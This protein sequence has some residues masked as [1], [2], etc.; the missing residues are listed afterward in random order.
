MI[1]V[2]IMAGGTGGHVMPGLAVAEALRA[3]GATLSWL[4]TAAG[5]EAELVAR[6]GIDIDFIRIKGLRKSGAAR[7]AAMPF[8]LAWAL[9]QAAAVMRRRRP[10]AALGMGGF[11]AAP[12]GLVAALLRRPLV[13][14]EQNRVAGLTNRLLAKVAQRRLSGFPDARGLPGAEWV[15]NP[16]RRAIVDLP[17]PQTRLAGR[18]GALRV[19]VVGGSR[20]AEAFNRHLPNLLARLQPRPQIRHQCGANNADAVAA[21]YRDAGI[22]AQVHAFIDDMASAY[23]WCDLAICRAGALTVAEVCAAGA[24]AL[25]VPYPHA[26]SDHQT[27][28]AA[29]LESQGAARLV[30]QD[31]LVRGDWLGALAEWQRE[32]A[33]L[34]AMAA[35]ARR[36]ARPDAADEVAR[37]CLE[38]ANG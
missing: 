6:A 28:N 33:P 31:D 5:V 15:G 36:L 37:I 30:A 11:A 16:V 1:R 14:H 35:A 3:R 38:A 18:R 13:I 21:R 25:L 22:R 4:G 26:V 34:A 12:G 32:R 7:A 2:L 24:A 8:M 9:A 19:L 29:W 10:H 23:A 20:G 17:P 27:A